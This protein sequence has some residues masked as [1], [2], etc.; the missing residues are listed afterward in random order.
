[1]HT[2]V[3]MCASGFDLF[4]VFVTIEAQHVACTKGEISRVSASE[5]KLK[6][7]IIHSDYVTE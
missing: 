3:V 4:E 5:F 1:M 7:K 6:Y 2:R